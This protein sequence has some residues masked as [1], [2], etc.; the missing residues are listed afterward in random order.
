MNCAICGGLHWAS[1]CMQPPVYSD[2]TTNPC[3][4]CKVEFRSCP[5]YPKA[6]KRFDEYA[7]AVYTKDTREIVTENACWFTQYISCPCA[8]QRANSV[9]GSRL[10]CSLMLPVPDKYKAL[11][12]K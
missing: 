2:S 11:E 10:Y 6:C 8:L 4:D 3:N 7:K 5:L 1:E 12:A 9:S